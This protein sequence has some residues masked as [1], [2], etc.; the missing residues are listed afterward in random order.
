MTK[1][2]EKWVDASRFRAD[3]S[4]MDHDPE[5]SVREGMSDEAAGVDVAETEASTGNAESAFVEI[6]SGAAT[7]LGVDRG[8]STGTGGLAAGEDLDPV[9][10]GDYWRQNYRRRPY[11]R[12]GKPYDYYEP[13][14]RFGWE[15]AADLE[16]QDRNFSDVESELARRWEARRAPDG[17]AWVDA[18]GPA[19]D[20]FERERR[21]RSR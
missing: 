5:D 14:Y 6:A 11:Y 12:T 16:F 17:P 15:T 8:E 9:A 2:D 13:G 10:A 18:V 1:E 19:R 20:A 3:P 21:R 4:V 7:G